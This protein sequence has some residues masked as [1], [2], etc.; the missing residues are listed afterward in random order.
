[1]N[2]QGL[3]GIRK[4]PRDIA[5][6]ALVDSCN[7]QDEA[8]IRTL[9]PV[10]SV[11]ERVFVREFS[12]P[13]EPPMWLIPVQSGLQEDLPLYIAGREVHCLISLR[14]EAHVVAA[15][16]YTRLRETLI[17][18]LHPRKI[19]TEV[20]LDSL[21]LAFPDAIGVRI[22]V[23]GQLVV[24][25]ASKNDMRRQDYLGN[26]SNLGVFTVRA[27]IAHHQPTADVSYG[28]PASPPPSVWGAT[29]CL[30]L[31]LLLPDGS[32]AITV[33]THGFVAFPR[34]SGLHRRALD[35][36]A[37]I[38]RGLQSLRGATEPSALVTSMNR[39]TQPGPNASVG[40]NVRL[41]TPMCTV[42]DAVNSMLK[43]S[44][45]LIDNVDCQRRVHL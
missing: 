17:D 36:Y 16:P 6:A 11:L 15:S 44:I 37:W 26:W 12:S 19:A 42:S 34:P 31:K 35:W 2:I 8:V 4:L 1:M 14:H 39:I 28:T 25:Y 27:E 24:L 9:H 3:D 45:L 23:S 22:L 33:P 32:Q 20:Q 10:L 18:G 30:G 40:K 43:M 21:R 5:R 38:R 13:P 29:V 7:N 41:G